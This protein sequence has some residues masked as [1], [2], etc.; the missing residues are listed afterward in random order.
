M[1]PGE[2]QFEKEVGLPTVV[3][4]GWCGRGLLETSKLEIVEANCGLVSVAQGRLSF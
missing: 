1:V 2:A 4:Q 3:Y